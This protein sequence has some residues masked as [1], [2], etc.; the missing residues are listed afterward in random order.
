VDPHTIL[1]RAI[2]AT[3]VPATVISSVT[4]SPFRHRVN[5]ACISF[6]PLDSDRG[7]KE[8]KDERAE[9]TNAN[10]SHPARLLAFSQSLRSAGSATGILPRSVPPS[11]LFGGSSFFKAELLVELVVGLTVDLDI[12]VDEVIERWAILPGR[13]LY[14]PAGG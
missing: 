6:M 7:Q 12:R 2:S 10:R 13:Q 1:R 4:T 3:L 8:L 14:V 9:Y 11:L 5:C